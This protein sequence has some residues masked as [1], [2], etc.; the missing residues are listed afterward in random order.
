M[1]M[2]ALATDASELRAFT[3]RTQRAGTQQHASIANVSGPDFAKGDIKFPFLVA[4]N[5]WWIPAKSYVRI[6]CK[7]TN[8]DDTPIARDAPI[9]PAMGA[10]AALFQ[11]AEFQIR[12][13]PV[14]RVSNL[15]SQVDQY[16]KRTTTS[17]TFMANALNSLDYQEPSWGKRQS[18]WNLPLA[19][20]GMVQTRYLNA[21]ALAQNAATSDL[22]HMVIQITGPAGGNPAVVTFENLALDAGTT[23]W[24][25]PGVLGGTLNDLQSGDRLFMNGGAPAANFPIRTFAFT[26]V[27]PAPAAG[28]TDVAYYVQAD[29]AVQAMAGQPIGDLQ[30]LVIERD[31]PIVSQRIDATTF[32]LI[33]QPPLSVFGLSHAL[34]SMSCEM[35][36]KGRPGAQYGNAAVNTRPAFNGEPAAPPVTMVPAGPVV[37]GAGIYKFTVGDIFMFTYQVESDRLDSGTYLLDLEECNC[38]QQTLDPVIGLNQKNFLVSPSTYQLGIAFQ[39]NSAGVSTDKPVSY[40]GWQNTVGGV[41]STHLDL[42]RMYIQYSNMTFPQPDMDPQYDAQAGIDFYTQRW[43]ES[44]L[45]SGQYWVPGGPEPIDDWMD[46]GPIHIFPTL[47]DPVDRSTNVVVNAFFTK[48]PQNASVL[49]FYMS[50][51]VATIMVDNGSVQQVDV[52][53]Q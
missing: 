15:V 47:R 16:V 3:S 43:M 30:N 9:A 39:D 29:P 7:I 33:W 1:A 2:Y 18:M 13:V 25:V 28:A 20:Q 50:R 10:A 26:I 36:L 51:K 19:D 42:N 11:S 49:C 31:V 44:M 8:G 32:E 48:A 53:D 40:F 17:A 22:T 12:G 38:N 27:G 37:V 34:P 41:T 21:G 4:G 52:Q 5:K 24:K 35:I 46:K 23:G 14:S 6:R 45:H